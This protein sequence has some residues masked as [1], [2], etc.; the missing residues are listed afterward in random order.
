MRVQLTLRRASAEVAASKT[1]RRFGATSVVRS[2]S[3]CT[4]LT[5]EAVPTA[6]MMG[7]A[8]ITTIQCR[9]SRFAPACPMG[10]WSIACA[11]LLALVASHGY[12]SIA[13][14][15]TV[16]YRGDGPGQAA[17]GQRQFW[18]RILLQKINT[19]LL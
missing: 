14:L 10:L 15:S 6:R 18:S 5:T 13:M 8:G 11:I 19:T 7:T 17:D 12:C 1:R 16:C 2:T 9:H 3:S 4:K